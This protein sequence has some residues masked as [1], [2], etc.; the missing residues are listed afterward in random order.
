MSRQMLTRRHFALIALL[1]LCLVG[2]AATSFAETLYKGKFNEVRL[3]KTKKRVVGDTPPDHPSDISEA[4][5]YNMLGTLHF[6]KDVIIVED[7]EDKRLFDKRGLDL[8]APYL[9]QA[10]N[11]ASPEQMVFF[12]YIKKA[13]F[14]KVFRNDRLI[15]GHCFVRDGELFIR[16]KKLYAK[17]FGD[18]DRAGMKNRLLNAKDM[19]VSLNIHSAHRSLGKKFIAMQI[20][21]DY[22]T[23]LE[24]L[25]VKEAAEEKEQEKKRK[26]SKL[27][28]GI[29]IPDGESQ[30]DDGSTT[31]QEQQITAL[32]EEP[33]TG[34]RDV[35]ARLKTLDKLKKN[36]LITQK[37]YNKKRTEI[38]QDL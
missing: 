25:A 37:E 31:S 29:P 30:G 20:D 15:M 21:H 6:D 26:E 34:G 24:E 27:I 19:K 4:K 2:S 1:V 32:Q 10:L 33:V 5:I 14:A 18:Y 23:D 36:K 9:A 12:R 11:K 17:V 13:P 7:V 38:L 3:V 35:M 28:V 16:F 22:K 8:L